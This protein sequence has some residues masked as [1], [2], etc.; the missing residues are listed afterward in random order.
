MMMTKQDKKYSVYVSSGRIYV[1]SQ[2][3][4]FAL[5]KVMLEWGINIDIQVESLEKKK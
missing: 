1:N 4:A 2:E 3:K 5:A